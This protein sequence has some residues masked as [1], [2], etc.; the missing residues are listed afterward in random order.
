VVTD[1][2]QVAGRGGGGW[3][4]K[5]EFELGLVRAEAFGLVLERGEPVLHRLVLVI[6]G[7]AL[8]G[9]EVSVYRGRVVF[10]VSGDG[11]KLVTVA[12]RGPAWAVWASATAL[13]ITSCCVV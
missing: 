4:V 11:G 2:D 12:A 7:A 5:V 8:E 13:L 3:L 6:D 1:L 10:K 9:A